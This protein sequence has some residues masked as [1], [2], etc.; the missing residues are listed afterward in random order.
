MTEGCVGSPPQPLSKE[1]KQSVPSDEEELTKTVFQ[2][3]GSEEVMDESK[4]EPH[5]V[6][7]QSNDNQR[8]VGE[9]N[10]TMRPL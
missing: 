7:L 9:T 1:S 5:T 2:S 6:P 10:F 4:N 3:E 8:A